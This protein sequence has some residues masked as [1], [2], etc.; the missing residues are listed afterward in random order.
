M[1][2][3]KK[4]LLSLSVGLFMVMACSEE[5]LEVTDE[6]R[7]NPDVFWQDGTQAKQAII[8]AYSPLANQFGWGRMMPI[9]TMYRSDATN[10]IAFQGVIT[11]ASNFSIEPTFGRLS[12]I[13]GEFWKT[14]LRANTI[15]VEVP[16]IED[17]SFTDVDRNAILGEAYFLRAYQYFY[18]VTMFRNVPLITVPAASLD[19]VKNAPADPEQV[20]QQIISDLQVAQSLL[21]QTWDSGNVGRATWGA[22]TGLLGKTYMYHSGIDN[23][24]EYA[25]AAVEF[26]KIIDSGVYTLMSNYADNFGDDQENNAESLFE[27]QHDDNGFSWGADIA[28]GLRTAAWEPDLAPPGFTSQS[29]MLINSW[30]KDAFLAETTTGGETDPRAFSTIVYDYP[31]AMLYETPFATGFANDLSTVTVRKYLDFRP[32]KTQADFGFGGFPSVINWRIMRYADILLLYAEAENETNG[33][34]GAA[35]DALNQVRT[36]SSMPVRV[37]S[38]Q[39]TLRQQIRDERVLELMFEGDRYHDLLR[40]GM[41]PDAITDELKSNLGGSQYVPGREYLPI[42]QIEVDTNPLYNQNPGYN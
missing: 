22:A 10:P 27:I 1:K 32:G 23:S 38:N 36:R 14:I 4:V 24:N 17:S 12:E 28:G 18:L 3:I 11:D 2:N 31:G 25:Q 6:N 41:I 34:S 21:P 40:W 35:L 13:W 29:G 5:N 26:K 33:G 8:G 9:H 37:T 20:W 15:L 19:E 7:L 30:V 42:P 16:A 39:A